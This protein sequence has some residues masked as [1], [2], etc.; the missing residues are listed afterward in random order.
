VGR[1]EGAIPERPP[2]TNSA[3]WP[4]R[5]PVRRLIVAVASTPLAFLLATFALA[6]GLPDTP[7]WWLGALAAGGLVAS[8]LLAIVVIAQVNRRL[9]G[10]ERQRDAFYREFGRLSRSAALGDISLSIAHDLNNPLAIMNE[11]A[12]WLLDLLEA[13]ELRASPSRQELVDSIG[14][15]QVQIGRASEFTRRV[16]HWAREADDAGSGVQLNTLITKTLYLLDADLAAAN[17]TVVK[18]LAPDA[19]PVAGTVA[20]L[21]QVLLHLMKNAVDAMETGGTLTLATEVAGRTV[22][23]SIGDTGTGIPADR[24][25]RIF[26]PFY[27]TKAE[28]LGSGLGLPIANWI[29]QRAG[30]SIGVESVAGVGTTFRVTLPTVTGR[31][32]RN[33]EGG[34]DG[35]N[36]TA[37]RR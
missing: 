17:V 27:T 37:A 4:E 20:E 33:G 32:P 9:A 22:S 19:P 2:V 26:E 7:R 1:A 10:I 6:I 12:G 35:G 3:R 34:H 24:L 31:P 16:L 13:P 25:D 36:P 8:Y 14:Q 15:I 18:R 11:E 30:G 28:G 21:R 5:P 23:A 29:V